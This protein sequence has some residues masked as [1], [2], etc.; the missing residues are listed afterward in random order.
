MYHY[1]RNFSNMGACALCDVYTLNLWSCN[2]RTLGIHIS[3]IIL[4][5]AFMPTQQ[6]LANYHIATA[7]YA[8]Y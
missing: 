2:P 1:D 8:V 6:I 7:F 3:D 4:C 5:K